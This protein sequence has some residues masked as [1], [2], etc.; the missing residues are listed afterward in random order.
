MRTVLQIWFISL[1]VGL[2]ASKNYLLESG[3]KME[4]QMETTTPTKYDGLRAAIAA[5]LIIGFWF[6]IGVILAVRTVDSMDYC[7][8][9]I[10]NS[11]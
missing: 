7:V 3:T 8:E 1:P 11:K 9:A 5:E 2:I 4:E 6:G 10:M